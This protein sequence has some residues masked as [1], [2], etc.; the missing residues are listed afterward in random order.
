M[1]HPSQ[2]ER[3]ESNSTSD[4]GSSSETLERV[5]RLNADF[6]RIRAQG[7]AVADLTRALDAVLQEDAGLP[8]SGDGV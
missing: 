6:A 4:R 8:P 5:E 2:S 7:Q 1:S 3:P